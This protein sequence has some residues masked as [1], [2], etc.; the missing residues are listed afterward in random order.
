MAQ[1]KRRDVTEKDVV[2]LKY[3][4]KLS[5]LLARLH[6]SGCARDKAGNRSLH[7]DQYCSLVLLFLFNPIVRSLRSIQQAGAN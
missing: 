1:A 3:F 6:G 7:F 4:D 2:G 5:P